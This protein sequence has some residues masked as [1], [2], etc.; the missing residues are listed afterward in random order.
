MRDIRVTW[1]LGRSREG[2][3]MSEIPMN[4]GYVKFGHVVAVGILVAKLGRQLMSCCVIFV[5]ERHGLCF[6]SRPLGSP[7][8]LAG[9]LSGLTCGDC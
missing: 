5:S 1:T 8:R 4:T 6:G 9:R 3:K 7:I 2:I